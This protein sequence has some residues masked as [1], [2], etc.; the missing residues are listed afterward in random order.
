M[1]LIEP[2]KITD[3]QLTQVTS[4]Y[5]RVCISAPCARSPRQDHQT[6]DIDWGERAHAVPGTAAGNRTCYL[7]WFKSIDSNNDGQ[8]DARELQKALATGNLHFSL[9]TVAHMIR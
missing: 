2:A 5:R 8:L 9:A 7:Q 3:E 4:C 1:Q 6:A